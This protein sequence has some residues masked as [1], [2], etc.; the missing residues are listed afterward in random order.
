MRKIFTFFIALVAVTLAGVSSDA[1]AANNYEKQGLSLPNGYPQDLVPL[2]DGYRIVSGALG[3]KGDKQEVWVKY[4]VDTDIDRVGAFYKEILSKGN[5]QYADKMGKNL[6]M[7]KG[8]LE[9]KTVG[10]NISTERL[11]DNFQTNV[12]VSITGD[13]AVPAK[14]DEGN[15]DVDLS[16]VNQHLKNRN[17]VPDDYPIDAV[18]LYGNEVKYGS[19]SEY[20]GKDIF[21][22]QVYSTE[23]KD[24]VLAVYKQLLK[25]A[26]KKEEGKL[27]TG[28]LTFGGVLE[29]Y[30]VSLMI[31]DVDIEGIDYKTFYTLQVDVLD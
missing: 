18:P 22:I 24:Q 30:K 21:V 13:I 8:E 3:N 14:A 4:M 16:N 27:G 17:K 26:A 7:L 19:K 25:S 9:G 6:F 20:K 5:L 1:N 23:D 31:G 28:S 29:N 15:T 11:Y 10:I 2:M 12:L